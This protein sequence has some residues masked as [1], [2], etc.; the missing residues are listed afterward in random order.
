MVSR[1]TVMGETGDGQSKKGTGAGVESGEC[2]GGD[3]IVAVVVSPI[4]SDT[5]NLTLWSVRSS[6]PGL[7]Y[8]GHLTPRGR[9]PPPRVVSPDS[10]GKGPKGP[11]MY[12]FIDTKTYFPSQT[13]F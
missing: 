1:D 11:Q 6:V 7:P 10:Q 12:F 4:I 9:S 2:Q 5:H 8:N 13:P 3:S